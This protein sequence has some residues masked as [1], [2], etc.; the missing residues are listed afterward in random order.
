[1]ADVFIPDRVLKD[2]RLTPSDK[3]LW[4]FYRS[5]GQDGYWGTIY[6]A[7]AETGIS[8]G[9]VIACNSNMKKSGFLHVAPRRKTGSMGQKVVRYAITP[10]NIVEMPRPDEKDAPVDG[11]K[12]KLC[13][14]GCGRLIYD[15]YCRD[16]RRQLREHY[17]VLADDTYGEVNV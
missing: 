1:M 4:A 15:R 13:V 5:F 2:T 7:V 12:R 11:D 8:H 14:G 17:N 10:E 16:C 3:I 6:N 9:G